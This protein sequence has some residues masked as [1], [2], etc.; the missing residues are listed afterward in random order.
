MRGHISSPHVVEADDGTFRLLYLISPFENLDIGRIN[1]YAEELRAVAQSLE[2][3]L[4]DCR[5]GA[6][7]AEELVRAIEGARVW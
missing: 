6:R 5:E 4:A 3:S 7:K 1:E 2:D